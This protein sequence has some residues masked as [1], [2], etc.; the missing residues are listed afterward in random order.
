M[1]SNRIPIS[2]ALLTDSVIDAYH[3]LSSPGGVAKWDQKRRGLSFPAV[4]E[5]LFIDPWQHRRLSSAS[6]LQPGGK[7]NV[8]ASSNEADFRL[9]WPVSVTY[10]G[11]AAK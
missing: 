10:R 7:Q 6:H 5:V 11:I 2:V 1:F 8:A 4:P 9:H 3:Q